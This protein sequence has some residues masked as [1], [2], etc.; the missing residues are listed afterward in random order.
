M[1]TADI[2]GQLADDLHT[3]LAL[4]LAGLCGLDLEPLLRERIENAAA[5]IAAELS[6]EATGEPV[7]A[8]IVTALWGQAEIPASWWRTPLGLAG[9]L[10]LDGTRGAEGITQQRAAD[11][12][13]VTRGTVAQLV[14]RGTLDRHPD[15]GV[16][17]SSVW[18]RM[19]RG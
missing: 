17:V 2:I 9:A 16:L 13:G 8:D 1:V 15:G 19:S 18:R 7:A 11:M 3:R 10:A 12:L 6:D 4:P 5:R 14:A